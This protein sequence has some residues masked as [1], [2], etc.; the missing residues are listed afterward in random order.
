[1]GAADGI[2]A[3]TEGASPLEPLLSCEERAGL[4]FFV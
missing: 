2:A 1:M 4:L 3:P